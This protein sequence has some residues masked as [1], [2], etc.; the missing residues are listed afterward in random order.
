ME[1][2]DLPSLD[3]ISYKKGMIANDDIDEGK[4]LGGTFIKLSNIYYKLYSPSEPWKIGTV[5]VFDIMGNKTFIILDNDQKKIYEGKY[6][7][8]IITCG[9]NEEVEPIIGGK[10]PVTLTAEEQR[11]IE[12][13]RYRERKELEREMEREKTMSESYKY[14]FLAVKDLDSDEIIGLRFN[15][16]KDYDAFND[17][18]NDMKH[19]EMIS[20]NLRDKED[21]NKLIDETNLEKEEIEG[22]MDAFCV[23]AVKSGGKKKKTYKKKAKKTKKAKQTKKAKKVKKTKKTKRVKRRRSS[24][25]R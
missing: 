13:E 14:L 22:W 17:E 1:K 4:L 9:D 25:K 7:N 6:Y 2:N 5:N 23:N 18:I 16:E 12:G 11:E 15:N 24:N 20:I 19:I 10:L 8:Y 21:V 3:V